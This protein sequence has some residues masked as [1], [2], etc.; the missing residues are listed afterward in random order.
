VLAVV[1]LVLVWNVRDPL[2]PSQATKSPQAVSGLDVVYHGNDFSIRVPREY[3]AEEGFGADVVFYV[4]TSTTAGSNLAEDTSIRVSELARGETCTAD[5][6]IDGHPNLE[7]KEIVEAGTRYSFASS[8]DAAA[9]NRYELL[10]YALPDLCVGIIYKIHFGVIENYPEGTAKEFD[11]DAL[12][13]E[14]DAIRRTLVI[15]Q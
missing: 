5:M 3:R 14:F 15:V 10:A 12:I 2:A 13:K 11:K 8:T 1:G 6:F 9:G 4:G 7:S